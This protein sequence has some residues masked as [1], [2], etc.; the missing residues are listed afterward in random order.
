M[1]RKIKNH[2]SNPQKDK[3]TKKMRIKKTVIFDFLLVLFL[4][5]VFYSF[6]FSKFLEITEIEISGLE[7]LDHK[8]TESEIREILEGKYLWIVPKNNILLVAEERFSDKVEEKF[9]KLEDVRTD[10]IFP[11]KLKIYA[12]ERDS[13]LVL[14]SKGDCFFIDK[15]GF[16]YIRADFD[17]PEAAQNNMIKLIDESGKR[18]EEGEQVLRSDF[19]DFIFSAKEELENTA[20]VDVSS[21]YRS[22]SLIAEEVIVQTSRGWDIYLSSGFPIEKS[23]KILKTVLSKQIT[24]KE[25]NEL[26]YIDLR[27][28]NKVFYRMKG[29]GAREEEALL[30]EKE[31]ENKDESE[32][33]SAVVEEVDK[34][35]DG[36]SA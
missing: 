6:I 14:C 1:R 18:I 7:T 33:E 12:K 30:D 9:K 16:S 5:V 23:A 2:W 17:S 3:I 32:K 28:E 36:A 25:A 27:S 8:E 22:K 24:L 11:D 4:G 21:E 34:K 20:G 10:K 35:K 29:D 15:N 26:E 31:G 13:V 19:V